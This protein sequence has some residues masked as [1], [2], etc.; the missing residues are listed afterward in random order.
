MTG[1][2]VPPEATVLVIG[3]G[4]EGVHE[5]LGRAL[6]NARAA[7]WD[8]LG[9]D[10][11]VA[12][13]A[14][15]KGSP[16][17]VVTWMLSAFVPQLV[18]VTDDVDPGGELPAGTD[19]L[20]VTSMQLVHALARVLGVPPTT[21]RTGQEVGAD[22]I[23]EPDDD[24][25]RGLQ[26]KLLGLRA[27]GLQVVEHTPRAS[28]VIAC[29]NLDSYAHEVMRSSLDQTFD[30][31][32]VVV[33]DDGS[34]DRTAEILRSYATNPKV[35]VVTQ[36]NIGGTGRM[37]LVQN[38]LIRESRGEFVAWV[39]GDDVNTP[40]RL[41]VQ[42]QAFD[43]DPGLDVCHAGAHFIDE[44]GRVTGRGFRPPVP[45]DDLSMLR[46]IIHTNLV[47]APSVMIRRSALERHGLFEQ[48]L[49][50]D[51]HFWLKT[52]GILRYRYLPHVLVHY[53]RHSQSLSTS[54][55]GV[56]RTVRDSMR[57]RSL[58]LA[59]RPLVDFFPELRGGQ[60]V[61]AEAEASIALGNALLQLDAQLALQA[62]DTAL[63]HGSADA[64]HNAAIAHVFAGQADQALAC[65]R[66][67]A[68]L[69]P[70][71][72]A[73]QEAWSGRG[74]SQVALRQPRGH[75]LPAVQE[76]RRLLGGSA[77]RWDGTTLQTRRAYL[78]F[79]PGR[80][81]LAR[82]ALQIWSTR[83]HS[84]NPL[85][86]IL[87]ARPG[88]AQDAFA[89]LVSLAAGLSLDDAADITIEEV[90]DLSMLPPQED[91]ANV[92]PDTE[93]RLVGSLSSEADLGVFTRWVG[94]CQMDLARRGFE[95]WLP[96]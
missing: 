12:A 52:A 6:A 72:A 4:A 47:G 82:A 80:E 76:A 2:T 41:E 70:T 96:A 28:I 78:A 71:C 58:V 17:D 8:F 30:D 66:T 45:Y 27:G 33:V 42:V 56:E 11:S 14:R 46:Q 3:A 68:S 53:R 44:L 32:E 1:T 20:A 10:P 63:G 21:W 5:P 18:L 22:Q 13:A 16:G 94:E 60:H 39:G 93:R 61:R 40:R 85:R 50:S 83:T 90:E 77:R 59:A 62:Y 55:S 34:T 31:Y 29:H 23:T 9:V 49:A 69:D 48:G 51:Y 36:P 57:L 19:V 64:F 38:R 65:A 89:D 15:L 54:A 88:Q 35:R 43:D 25:V 79:A 75:L 26:Q 24:S 84:T 81:D 74:E 91:Q 7:G 86:W 92:L 87:P 95:S 73:L 37:D 67:A